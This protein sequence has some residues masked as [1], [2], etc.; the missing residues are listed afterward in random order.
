M[1]EQEARR[2]SLSSLEEVSNADREDR[3][4][5]KPET[6]GKKDEKEYAQLQT[7]LENS[8]HLPESLANAFRTQ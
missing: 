8:A 3:R 1:T 4:T 2:R 6:N 5:V 7:A